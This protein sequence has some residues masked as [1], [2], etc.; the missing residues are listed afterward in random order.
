MINPEELLP[1]DDA[2]GADTTDQRSQQDIH[3]N[4][5]DR[6]NIPPEE[7]NEP[8]ID[9]LTQSYRAAESSFTLNLDD[10]NR[11]KSNPTTSDEHT[12]ASKL[13]GG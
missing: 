5:L 11:K 8:A 10:E 12:T 3:S 2:D 6:E 9:L 4:G 7:T 1:L 13:N